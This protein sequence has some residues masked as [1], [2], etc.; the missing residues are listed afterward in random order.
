MLQLVKKCRR[1][2]QKIRATAWL[3]LEGSSADLLVKTGLATAGW[4]GLH[5]VGFPLNGSTALWC[6]SHFSPFLVVYSLLMVPFVP[7][8][9][10]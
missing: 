4:S 3:Q 9:S 6:I 7:H 8:A 10:H 2:L 5:T 1:V